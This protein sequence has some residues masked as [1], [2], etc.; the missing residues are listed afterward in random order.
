MKADLFQSCGHC[1]VFQTCWHIEF[2]TFIASSLRTSKSSAG[3]PSPP[4]TLFVVML[5]KAHL[6]SHS[7]MSGSKWVIT[8]SCLSGHEDHFAGIKDWRQEEEGMTEGEMVGW[9]H[10]LNRHEF[11]QA[12]GAG[13][14][15]GG[16]VCCSPFSH[17]E[18][19]MTEWLNWTEGNISCKDGQNKG[20]KWYGPDRSRRY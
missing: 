17:K 20:Q 18:S 6:T 16:L 14:G 12:L 2:G 3:I 5:P 4:L 7:R 13:D 9:Y 19:D 1:W 8:P 11:E 15:Q 10:W